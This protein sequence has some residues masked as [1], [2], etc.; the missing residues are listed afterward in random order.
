MET[1]IKT[2]VEYTGAIIG[3]LAI[4]FIEVAALSLRLDGNTLLIVVFLL[5]VAAV[6]LIDKTF[7]SPKNYKYYL[8]LMVCS[9][10]FF[11]LLSVVASMLNV[12]G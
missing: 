11:L 7:D 2:N 6:F 3:A 1:Q 10:I 12:W 8:L 5:P 9:V 4:A